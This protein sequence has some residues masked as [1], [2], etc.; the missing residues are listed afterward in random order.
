MLE[1]K[2]IS[3]FLSYLLSCR[4]Y[5]YIYDIGDAFDAMQCAIAGVIEGV[6]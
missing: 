2:A 1:N 4:H 3:V 5:L 6:N